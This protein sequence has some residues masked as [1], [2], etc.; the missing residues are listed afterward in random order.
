VP[1]H[2]PGGQRVRFKGLAATIRLEDNPSFAGKNG[3]IKTLPRSPRPNGICVVAATR[4][5]YT[6]VCRPLPG[7]GTIH[8]RS[9]VLSGKNYGRVVLASGH[10]GA[11]LWISP[12][13]DDETINVPAR[14][15]RLVRT[16]FRVRFML[17]GPVDI[18]PSHRGRASKK[19]RTTLNCN[20][21]RPLL[22]KMYE[23][24]EDIYRPRT[25]QP[26]IMHDYI[27]RRH[28]AA[29]DCH[30]TRVLSELGSNTRKKRQCGCTFNRADA[31]R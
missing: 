29:S 26:I 30:D 4:M 19:G 2:L 18:G 7:V 21:A 23:R 27:Q 9:S 20:P 5:E 31:T 28:V 13:D 15:Q 6:Y 22:R 24:A 8:S 17:K 12:R 14:S 25:R 11:W 10:F 3:F 16:V 1:P